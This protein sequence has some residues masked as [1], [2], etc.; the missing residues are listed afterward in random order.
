MINGRGRRGFR[1]HIEA[2]LHGSLAGERRP[3]KSKVCMSRCE[4]THP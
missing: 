1:S 3:A 4:E 2:W